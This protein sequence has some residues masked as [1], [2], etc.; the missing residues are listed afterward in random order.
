MMIK[1][2]IAPL[3]MVALLAISCTKSVKTTTSAHSNIASSQAKVVSK[4]TQSDGMTFGKTISAKG[5]VSYDDMRSKLSKTTK[6]D[7]V[8]VTGMVEAVCQAKGCWMNIVSEKGAPSMHVD[9]KDYAFFMPKDLAGKK[10]VMLGNAVK[11]VISV[12][13]LCHFAADEGKSKEEIAKIKNPKEEVTFVAS[14]VLIL[15]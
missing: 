11:K 1:Q 12:E 10:V 6:L 5:A 14:G 2:F 4:E 3:S 15:D 9:F 13:E 7:N 8:K